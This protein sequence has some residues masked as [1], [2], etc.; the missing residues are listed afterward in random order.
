MTHFA[1]LGKDNGMACSGDVFLYNT[2]VEVFHP[3]PVPNRTCSEPTH[4]LSSTK[5][6]G[7]AAH[8]FGHL[9]QIA[10][11]KD[12]SAL[13]YGGLGTGSG[14]KMQKNTEEI[15]SD[16]NR[17]LVRDVSM[18]PHILWVEKMIED[19]TGERIQWVETR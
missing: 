4:S 17:R 5:Y 15:A 3:K 14:G 8:E 18:R 13:M 2:D 19:K 11:T 7:N 6:A 12:Q 1:S 9:I 16:N 10:H